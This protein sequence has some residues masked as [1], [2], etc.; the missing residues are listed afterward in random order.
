MTQRLELITFAARA[1]GREALEF[2]FDYPLKLV[3][4]AGPR[5]SLHYYLYSD[6]LSWDAMRLDSAG[7]PRAWYRTTGAVYWPAYIAWYGL[8]N[9][10][11]HLRRGDQTSLDIFLNQVDWL[12]RHALRRPDGAVIWPMNFDYPEGRTL[13][14]APWISAH[15][16][17]LAISAMVRGWRVTRRPSLL[18]LLTS[19]AKVYALD[20]E[21]GGIRVSFGGH[22]LYTEV[23]G[24]KPPGILDGFMTSMLGLYNLF[25]ETQDPS[26]K[27]LFDEGI[28][29]LKYALPNWDYR[30]KWSWYGN[31]AYLSPPPYHRLNRL[32]LSVLARLSSE[33]SFA[34]YAAHWDTDRLSRPSRAEIYLMFLLTKNASRLRRRTWKLRSFPGCKPQAKPGSVTV[35]AGK[36][37]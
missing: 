14:K 7:I 12:E 11:H 23:P 10:G 26:V 29:G 3:P 16:Q 24:G 32:L 33:P 35:A 15:A 6:A 8:V 13:L 22:A 5:E 21:A 30:K 27:Q 1:I 4:E 31:Q 9:L 18:D 34:D 19:S 20:C 17:G 28:A 2:R 37:D 36:P 25:V